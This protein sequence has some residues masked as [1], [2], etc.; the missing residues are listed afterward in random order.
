M[1]RGGRR[2]YSKGIED[3]YNNIYSIEIEMNNA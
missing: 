2:R 1:K 3:V